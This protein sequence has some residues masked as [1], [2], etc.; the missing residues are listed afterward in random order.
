MKSLEPDETSATD[1]ATCPKK[2]ILDYVAKNPVAAILQA[3][4]VGFAAGMLVRLLEGHKEKEPEIDLKR[5]P[6][7]DDAKFHLGSLVLPFLWPAWHAAQERYG[8]ST[9]TV[10]DAVRQSGAKLKKGGRDRLQKAE[11]WAEKEADVLT[12]LGRKGAKGVEAWVENEAE[13]LTE[14]GRKKAKDLEEWVEKE[15]LPAAETG[16]KKLRKFFP[17]GN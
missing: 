1:H 4:A 14:L 15:I 9:D 2:A 10:R 7:L 11:K 16:W 12:E 5:K 3:L 17:N 6:T 13:H 8:H